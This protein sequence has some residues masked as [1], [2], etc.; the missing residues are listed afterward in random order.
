VGGKGAGK[1]TPPKAEDKVL[2]LELAL[3]VLAVS[4]WIGPDWSDIFAEPNLT[5]MK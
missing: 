5:E 3:K 2:A 4:G 1:K